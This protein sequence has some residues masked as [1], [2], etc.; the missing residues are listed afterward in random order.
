MD[1]GFPMYSREYGRLADIRN[2][3]FR[4]NDT[5]PLDFH[6]RDSGFVNGL[7]IYTSF[8]SIVDSENF[9]NF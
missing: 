7:F 6:P 1:Y 8:D 3:I 4:P 5:H 9:R 2:S